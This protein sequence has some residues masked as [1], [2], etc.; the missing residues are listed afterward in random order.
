MLAKKVAFFIL[1][2][3]VVLLIGCK[4][5]V[6]EVVQYGTISVS[7]SGIEKTTRTI[8][9][10]IDEITCSY[11][12]VYG[13]HSTFDA[14]NP[15]PD[16]HFERRFEA[17]SCSVV[18]MAGIWNVYVE[19]Y[20]DQGLLIAR[21]ASQSV[22]ITKDNTT[23]SSFTLSYITE[24]NGSVDLLVRI[25][26]T[27]PVAKVS[28]KI[29]ETDTVITSI[30]DSVEG[31]F[32][33]S[34]GNDYTLPVGDYSV[35]LKLFDS[36]DRLLGIPLN[37]RIHVYANLTSSKT[38]TDPGKVVAPV[39][40]SSGSTPSDTTVSIST[41]TDGASIYYTTDGSAPSARSTKYTG[42]FS[43]TASMTVKAIAVHPSLFNS[44]VTSESI[45]LNAAT[46][47]ASIEAGTYSNTQTVVLSCATAGASIRYTTDGSVPTSESTL[48]SVPVAVDHN[49]T[50]KAVA[51]ATGCEDS[52]VMAIQYEIKVA[53][54]V[55]S[56][57]S[58]LL[59]S[60]TV[61]RL[62]SATN[63]ASIYYT[64]D[65][66]TPSTSSI[67]Y[68]DSGIVINRTTEVKAIA[69]K[70]GCSDSEVTSA[71]YTL[72]TVG[73]LGPAGGYVF[74][75]CDADNDSGNADGLISSE[76]GWRFLEAAPADLRVVGG[77]PTVD[78]CAVGY[79]SAETK[80]IFGYYRATDDGEN[81]Y[82]DETTTYSENCTGT[83]IGCGMA[84]T[85]K[86]VAAMGDVAYSA[87]SGSETTPDYAARLCAV[88]EYTKDG[89]TFD[90][91][92]LPSKDELNLMYVNLYLEGLGD[93][94]IGNTP[95]WSSSENELYT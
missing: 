35:Q 84:N 67:A 11:Y 26:D 83:A 37:D 59:E 12:K 5:D 75:D 14:N 8:E 6:E 22:V 58:G 7:A 87:H 46:P 66:S 15:N 20:N 30:P 18:I 29:G 63:G 16:L 90:D 56:F 50:L 60:E 78:S 45:I 44:N 55:F 38:W 74:Y 64:L 27:T 79:S 76:C 69:V 19:G 92:F 93:L 39:I 34:L 31:Y 36:S 13:T 57:D 2:I 17:S 72:Y 4:A 61:L 91:W 53:D 68:T 88:L 32:N 40:T 24:G 49:L 41:E 94:L 25:P 23:N 85:Q 89:E 73:G 54:P 80:Y 48:Y 9:P 86:L 21:S 52:P 1:I 77:V 47:Y 3:S 62:S 82:V 28:F 71:S 42:P 51:F 65:G 70:N 43:A 95:Y 33:V 10:A 81:L